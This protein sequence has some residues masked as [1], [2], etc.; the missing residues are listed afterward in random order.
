[1]RDVAAGSQAAERPWSRRAARAPRS[2]GRTARSAGCPA[3]WS[4]RTGWP[5]ASWSPAPA[6]AGKPTCSGSLGFAFEHPGRRTVM[7]SVICNAQGIPYRVSATMG[8]WV[9]HPLTEA[10]NTV[11]ELLLHHQVG[12]AVAL[13]ACRRCLRRAPG[14]SGPSSTSTLAI[15]PLTTCGSCAHQAMASWRGI[16]SA[17]PRPGLGR[18]RWRGPAG[19]SHSTLNLGA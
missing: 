13:A 1:M 19:V 10:D 9:D 12:M 8:V 4:G 16:S 11:A 6:A 5:S 15:R 7:V 14:A 18:C 3:L 2:P 17:R